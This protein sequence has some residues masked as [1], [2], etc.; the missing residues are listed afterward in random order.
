MSDDG[1]NYLA[2]LRM[3]LDELAWLQTQTYERLKRTLSGSHHQHGIVARRAYGDEPGD[4]L[5]V[6]NIGAGV[7]AVQVS[8]DDGAPGLAIDDTGELLIFDD[9]TIYLEQGTATP[10]DDVTANLLTVPDDATWYTLVCRRTTSQ[11]E[12]GTI[13]VTTSSATVNGT[14]TRF[15][16]FDGYT[17][18]GYNR[19]SRLRI[20]AADTANGNDGTYEIDTIVSDT[21]L[22]LRTA[23][24]GTT[25]TGMRFTIAGDFYGSPPADPDCHNNPAVEFEL[26]ARTVTPASGDIIV[27]DVKYDSGTSAAVQIIDRRRANIARL[28]NVQSNR[29]AHVRPAITIDPNTPYTDPVVVAA[30]AFTPTNAI[31]DVKALRGPDNNLW[32]AYTENGITYWAE[33]DR[34]A[35]SWSSGNALRGGASLKPS[36]VWLP[37]PI[38]GP[39]LS[40][41]AICVYNISGDGRLF[42]RRTLNGGTTWSTETNV[43]NPTTVDAN[44]TVQNAKLL[45]LRSGRLLIVA[46]YY[47]D[48]AS[49][50]DIKYAFSDD[51]GVTWDTNSGAGYTIWSDAIGGN[52][53][54]HP[55][56]VQDP[57]TGDLFV[58][59]EHNG[60]GNIKVALGPGNFIDENTPEFVVFPVSIAN[61]EGAAGGDVY[62]PVLH[63]VPGGPLLLF[64]SAVDTGETSVWCTVIGD[65]VYNS[66]ILDSR[67]LVTLDGGL[68][69]TQTLSVGV[70]MSRAGVLDVVAIDTSASPDE[71][72]HGEFDV[73]EVPVNAGL[74]Y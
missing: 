28:A 16:R 73:I 36:I 17:T 25:E 72:W 67:R 40:V 74:P 24:G 44:D 2:N 37:P 32:L 71:I 70:S 61:Y 12:P 20:D 39:T 56:V 7:I 26:V 22:T 8:H 48:S 27:A 66:K 69:S 42:S 60:A 45:L 49:R 19:G 41:Y 58:A 30:A 31:T 15:T 3:G 9:D 5:V 63:K 10:I 4:F 1:L 59:W 51:Y 29:G 62:D 53:S 38:G 55:D 65:G 57:I 64:F 52:D 35:G 68:V 33:Y 46:D 11:Y 43:W 18:D 34:D 13:D 47:D 21:Q 50:T 54:T 23:I 14:G 6:S